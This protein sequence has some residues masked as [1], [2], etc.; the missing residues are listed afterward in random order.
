MKKVLLLVTLGLMTNL[1]FAQETATASEKCKFN[2]SYSIA[3]KNV[4][5]GVGLGNSPV[6]GAEFSYD[7]TNWLSISVAPTATVLTG[8]GYGSSLKNAVTVKKDKVSLE[9][10]DMYYFQGDGYND[11]LKYGDS[12]SHLVNAGVKYVDSKFYGLVQATAYKASYDKNNGVYFEAGYNVCKTVN[13]NAGYVTD[14]S[15]NN[16]RTKEGITHIGL[17]ITKDVKVCDHNS[18]L[19]TTLSVN[20][21]KNTVV[22]AVG[23]SANPIQFAVGLKF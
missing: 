17:T 20:P 10:A 14:A 2:S 15:A 12:T 11:Y 23:V 7:A 16:F 4:Y 18:K 3:S 9:V 22:N 1:V 8:G 21:T 19:T 13:L 5:R 6:V